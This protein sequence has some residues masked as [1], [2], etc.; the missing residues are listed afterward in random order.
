MKFKSVIFDLDGTLLDTVED[1]ADSVNRVL[2]AKGLPVYDMDFYRHKVGYGTASLV[3]SVLPSDRR[4]ERDISD[5][6]RMLR[7]DYEKNWAVKTTPFN[8]ITQALKNISAGGVTMA[9]L[10]NK[11]HEI[12]ALSVDRFFSG[13]RFH[14]VRG[15]LD[16]VALK[17]D[18]A[19]ALEIAGM[20]CCD[21]EETVFVGDTAVDIQTAVA[22]GMFPL[23]VSW[24]FRPEELEDAGAARIITHPAQMTQLF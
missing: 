3:K 19:A 12:T 8:G 1:I 18:P 15:Q 6:I 4:S 13:I 7:R 24:G 2:S 11:I 23:G 22:A 17:P 10:S 5:F 20:M 14:V 21:P 16:G 9:V